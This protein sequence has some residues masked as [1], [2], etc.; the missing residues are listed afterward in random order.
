MSGPLLGLILGIFLLFYTFLAYTDNFLLKKIPVKLYIK[1]NKWYALGLIL[2]SLAFMLGIIGYF[3]DFS[4]QYLRL[5]RFLLLV[6][7]L[8][9][10]KE[11]LKNNL[12]EQEKLPQF[13]RSLI[14]TEINS[15]TLLKI[16]GFLVLLLLLIKSIVAVD[17]RS[18]DTWIYQL[19]F[20]ARIW[21]LVTKEEYV[22]PYDR[23]ILYGHTTM[24]GNFLQGF[25]W[26]LFG[27]KNP[28]GA[29]LVSFFSLIIFFIFL[30]NYLKIPIYLASISILA[31]PLIH[32]AATACY[33]DLPG[34]IGVSIALIMTY[35]LYIRNDFLNWK[36][37][38]VFTLA[39]ATA[40]NIKYLMVPPIFIIICFALGR[41]IWL[42]YPQWKQQTSAEK[43]KQITWFLS[44][45][46]LISIVIFATEFKNLVLYGNP[47]YPMKIEIAGVTLNHIAEPSSDYM[48]DKIK[49]M[50]PIQRWIFSLLEIGAFNEQRPLLWTIAMDYVP[51]DDDTFGMGG[52][53]SI[54]VIFNLLLFIALC[55][56]WVKET[57]IALILFLIMS[58]ITGFLPFSYQLRYYMYW[59]ITLIS[60]NLYLVNEHQNLAQ[61][62]PIINLRNVGYSALVIL[63]AFGVITN[64]EYTYP[65]RMSLAKFMTDSKRVDPELLVQIQ[66]NDK[67]CIV[68]PYPLVFLY[69]SKF[70][71]GKNYSLKYEFAISDEYAKE[72]CQGYRIIKYER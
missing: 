12:E 47:F 53:F 2:I 62:L 6:S 58:L 33:I 57:K 66:D 37:V 49:A 8:I 39:S 13:V 55:T 11:S 70:N 20:A 27:L 15:I 52:Y 31:V 61:K 65:N 16:C 30:R 7:G 46:F 45:T 21:G 18:G 24:L 32:I 28:Q 42:Y 25:F 38:I 71:P 72:K 5:L 17:W 51:L 50:F 23:E 34:N 1:G 54:Y 22:L 60:L 44:L 69:N 4:G 68:S 10:V 9:T 59:I 40:A 19:P 26:Y 41:I 64:W 48:S 3:M 35:L 29:N 43:L 56:R 67:V 63:I 36:N 14:Q